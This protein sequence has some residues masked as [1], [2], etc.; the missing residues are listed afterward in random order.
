[1]EKQDKINVIDAFK[2]HDKDTGSAEVQV[3]ILSARI[4]QLTAHMAANKQDSHTKRNLLR[5]VGQ[6]RR[7]L[8][9]LRQEDA[10]RY[11]DII[12]KLGLRK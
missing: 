3:A 1:M 4:V 2:R 12:A 6:R 11:Q 7:M 10:T 8:A 9:Y 5:L